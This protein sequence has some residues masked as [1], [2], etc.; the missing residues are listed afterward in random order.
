MAQVTNDFKDEAILSPVQRQFDA[1]NARDIDA[2]MACWTEDCV[3]YDYPAE[4]RAQGQQEVRA[5]HVN[6]FREP[7]LQAALKT[8]MVADDLV[9]NHVILTRTFEH[10][11]G[12]SEL[13]A[14]YQV[15]EGLI[16]NAWM[17]VGPPQLDVGG[18]GLLMRLD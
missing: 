5:W 12:T 13:V 11:P 1:F 10:G 16:S 4:L 6:R 7:D 18:G 2:F 15:R 17:K 3:Y 9:I 14:I 8:R